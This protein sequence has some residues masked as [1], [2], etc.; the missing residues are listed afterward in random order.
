MKR[1]FKMIITVLLLVGAMTIS[2]FAT[3]GATGYDPSK[4]L[5]LTDVEI[6]LQAY[7]G[8]ETEEL[9]TG[10]VKKFIS[11]PEI[12]EEILNSPDLSEAEKEHIWQTVNYSV[13]PLGTP[14]A[15]EL[16]GFT[17]Y[18]QSTNVTCA[19]ATLRQTIKYITGVDRGEAYFQNLTGPGP[20][21]DTVLNVVNAHQSKTQYVKRPKSIY[22]YEHIKSNASS[23]LQLN[24]P[25]IISVVDSEANWI[26]YPTDGHFMN[27]T[28]QT[29]NGVVW[30][31][32]DPYGLSVTYGQPGLRREMSSA[33]VYNGMLNLGF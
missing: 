8:A 28:G 2:A 31:I 29:T 10:V 24:Y 17:Y 4:D 3:N 22:S 19:G 14:V 6:F 27:I 30:I 13:S 33:T 32:G 20:G 18:Q 5:D 23:A 21:F 11:T 7:L 9:K 25:P 26:G 1:Q 16:T 12:F 15:M